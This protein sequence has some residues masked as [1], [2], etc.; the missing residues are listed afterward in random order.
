MKKDIENINDIK[1]LV[2]NF[3]N[4]LLEDHRI[5]YFFTDVAKLNFENH[6]PKMYA[7]WDSILFGSSNFSGNPMQAHIELNKK[8][9]IDNSHF[10][11]WQEHWN[12]NADALFFGPKTDEI[13][14]RAKNIASLMMFKIGI[15]DN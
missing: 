15:N 7:F 14:L 10:E 3:Y 4:K 5:A 1:N 12:E 11:V 6:L 8:S 9:S 13:K 2:D